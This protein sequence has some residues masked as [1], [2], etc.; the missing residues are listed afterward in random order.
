[1][2]SLNEAADQLEHV[3]HITGGFTSA[4]CTAIAEHARAA[5]EAAKE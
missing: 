4:D 2:V 3:A 5:L 1:V